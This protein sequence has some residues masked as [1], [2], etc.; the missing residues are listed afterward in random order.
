MC[1]KKFATALLFILVDM[2]SIFFGMLGFFSTV[3]FETNDIFN[4]TAILSL[5]GFD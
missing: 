4:L 3:E 2:W 1:K 5:S